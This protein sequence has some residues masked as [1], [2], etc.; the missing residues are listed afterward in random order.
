M[1]GFGE[2]VRR[3]RLERDYSQERFAELCGL[4]RT[5]IGSI[6]RGEKVVTIVTADKLARALGISLTGL[7]AE[8]EREQ[9]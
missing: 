4:H 2:T 5:Y 7:F 6:E 8:L 9:P 1:R 3:L